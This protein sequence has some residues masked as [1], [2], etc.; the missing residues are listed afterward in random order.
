MRQAGRA[1]VSSAGKRRG[2]V[3]RVLPSIAPPRG[4]GLLQLTHTSPT[5]GFVLGRIQDL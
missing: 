2:G 3:S 5:Q 1:A 4:G